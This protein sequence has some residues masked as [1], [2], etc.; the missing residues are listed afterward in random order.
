M[1][2]PELAAVATQIFEMLPPEFKER[3]PRSW[4]LQRKRWSTDSD[5]TYSPSI[6]CQRASS[7]SSKRLKLANDAARSVGGDGRCIGEGR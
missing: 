1:E 3:A 2:L 5:S 6:C 4:R 7:R